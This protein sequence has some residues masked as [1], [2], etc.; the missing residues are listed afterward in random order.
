MRPGPPRSRAQ[1]W[2]KRSKAVG[3]GS[4]PCA[5]YRSPPAWGDSRRGRCPGRQRGGAT[6][7]GALPV[8]R[9]AGRLPTRTPTDLGA[10]RTCG[11]F[12]GAGWSIFAALSDVDGRARAA[13]ADDRSEHRRPLR[14]CPVARRCWEIGRW[15]SWFVQVSGLATRPS[16]CIAGRLED[17][18]AMWCAPLAALLWAACWMS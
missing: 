15:I 2:T 6:R 18:W 3:A 7:C 4:R 17:K 1:R 16:G 5:P 8:A 10:N 13:G 9:M 12:V 14:A 11:R